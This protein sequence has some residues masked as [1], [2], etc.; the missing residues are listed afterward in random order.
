MS[1]SRSPRPSGPV[2]LLHGMDDNVIPA[3]E[4]T[5]LAENLRGHAPVRLLLSPLISHAEADQAGNVM[6]IV[7]LGSFW[8]EL[9]RR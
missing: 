8:G 1:P 2:Y 3:I 9:L 7:R 5:R 4:S 6:D